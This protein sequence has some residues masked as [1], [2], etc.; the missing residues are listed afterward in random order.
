MKC[1]AESDVF[2]AGGFEWVIV[3]YRC[4][5]KFNLY[6]M[7][8]VCLVSCNSE[9]VIADVEFHLI[10]KND[11]AEDIHAPRESKTASPF[12]FMYRHNLR[13]EELLGVCEGFPL[14]D[15]VT[16]M[17]DLKNI[18]AAKPEERQM[19]FDR[20]SVFL[21]VPEHGGAVG[22]WLR[23]AASEEPPS[24]PDTEAFSGSLLRYW[25]RQWPDRRYWI[26]N[27][28]GDGEVSVE[29]CLNEAKL[30][31]CFG[32]FCNKTD[33][34]DHWVTLFKE[35][36]TS[37]ETFRPIHD[38]TIVVF[39]KLFEPRHRRMS[40]F[41]HFLFRKTTPCPEV[42]I[43]I[44]DKMAH[45]PDDEAYEAYI[46]TEALD[47]TDIT[48]KESSLDECGARS[49]SVVIIRKAS[50]HADAPKHVQRELLDSREEITMPPAPKAEEDAFS[51]V[52]FGSDIDDN[53]SHVDENID[54]EDWQLDAPQKMAAKDDEA[55]WTIKSKSLDSV[56]KAKGPNKIRRT[57]SEPTLDTKG[58][59]RML[60]Q[61]SLDSSKPCTDKID[62][63]L[64]NL[65]VDDS[66]LL[67]KIPYQSPLEKT[68]PTGNSLEKTAALKNRQAAWV[69]ASSV[70]TGD[71]TNK[72]TADAKTS[73]TAMRTA[74]L[75]AAAR[76]LL[77]PDSP[78]PAPKEPPMAT[79]KE[80]DEVVEI[81]PSECLAEVKLDI[82][83]LTNDDDAH[84]HLKDREGRAPTQ[85]NVSA[86]DGLVY[87]L[88]DKHQYRLKVGLQAKKKDRRKVH[89]I[90][91]II[92]EG[93]NGQ[94]IDL[95]FHEGGSTSSGHRVV[96][97]F[98]PRSMPM[99]KLPKLAGS[100]QSPNSKA[101]SV[102]VMLT[103]LVETSTLDKSGRWTI[104]Q[105]ELKK[106]LQ[107]LL[108][109][110]KPNLFAGR[111]KRFSLG[112][113]PNH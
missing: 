103:V 40:Y 24:K 51:F 84:L 78:R 21:D 53:S 111:F 3:L 37:R 32:D 57:S 60:R 87:V 26:C 33:D 4:F 82:E 80:V 36:K 12:H 92:A 55:L 22:E 19:G 13:L 30:L 25:A 7:V 90:S 48:N 44:A 95:H 1:A 81:E 16:V 6:D 75:F 105:T 71:K 88:H 11:G 86:G 59:L 47:L 93:A 5:Q 28:S 89:L 54:N 100:F 38:D 102:E 72:D 39:C 65:S 62:L 68:K 42:L 70:P 31:E 35:D 76:K 99:Q 15:S 29:K 63:A 58:K 106:S 45:L 77:L 2:E 56:L 14:K 61:K 73:E 112:S 20:R 98:C 109:S 91:N 96:A 66:F 74:E 104:E 49:G 18:R 17:F 27:R 97:L 110:E 46:K 113:R 108:I 8:Q 107:C 52:P 41:G 10:N 69:K 50:A 64:E 85:T 9:D 79:I 94:Q 67:N 83:Q 43:T 101:V 34:G 23:Q